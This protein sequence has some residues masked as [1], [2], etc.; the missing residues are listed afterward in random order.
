MCK[1]NLT[2]YEWSNGRFEIDN[3]PRTDE[4]RLIVHVKQ[5]EKAAIEMERVTAR[6]CIFILEK[7]EMA[8]IIIMC[9]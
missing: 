9:A 1:P 5:F 2:I 6:L 8:I 4:N 7:I 3:L